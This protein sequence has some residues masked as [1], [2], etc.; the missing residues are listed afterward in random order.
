MINISNHPSMCWT[1]KQ[2][3]A[4]KELA[5]EIIDISFPQV[6]PEMD[7]DWLYYTANKMERDIVMYGDNDSVVVH[8]M[9]EMGLTYRVCARLQ[10]RGYTVYHSTTTRV[11][12]EDGEKKTS[13]FSFCRFR[14]Y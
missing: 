1:E 13:I 5:D 3:S 2:I 9:G 7:E 12:V 8:I 14:M 10:A 4:A 6:P 11:A